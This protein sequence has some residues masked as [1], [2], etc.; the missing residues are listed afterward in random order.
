MAAV[1][2]VDVY[3]YRLAPPAG[4]PAGRRQRG[5]APE[6]LLL[7]RA[8]GVRYEGTWRMVGGKV[9]PGEPGWRAALREVLEE[10]G[11]QPVRAW[12]LPSANTFYEWREDRITVAPAFAVELDGD[13]R[14]DREH[15]RF[16]WVPV[17]EAVA[18]LAWP[19]QV[20]LIQLAD[21]LL[22]ADAVAADWYLPLEADAPAR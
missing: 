13:P 18:L 21:R 8:P 15:D 9:E 2:V 20:R 11:R 10:T 1:R 3:P 12:A 4:P 22:R 6:W 19:E 5:P 16:A 17:E 14:L 7:R